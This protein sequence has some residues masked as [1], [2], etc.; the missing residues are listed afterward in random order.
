MGCA[1]TATGS[2]SSINNWIA[3]GTPATCQRK[4][5]WMSGGPLSPARLAISIR[6]AWIDGKRDELAEHDWIASVEPQATLPEA[7][8]IAVTRSDLTA[9]RLRR[10]AARVSEQAALLSE[11]D[12]MQRKLETAQQERA[13]AAKRAAGPLTTPG[14]PSGIRPKLSLAPR[15]KCA[16]GSINGRASWG[17][18]KSGQTGLGRSFESKNEERRTPSPSFCRP[19][20]RAAWIGQHAQ[21]LALTRRVNRTDRAAASKMPTTT[22]PESGHA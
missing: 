4:T 1:S 20:S 21:A 5:I 3:F 19:S 22:S 16:P 14:W 7:Y 18:P 9:D 10:E 17:G 12:A 8:D 6:A 11:K 13:V 15:G 2:P